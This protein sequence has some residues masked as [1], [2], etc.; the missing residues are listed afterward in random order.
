MVFSQP[1]NIILLHFVSIN[2]CIAAFASIW[3]KKQNL[4][5]DLLNNVWHD[6]RKGKDLKKAGKDDPTRIL[7]KLNEMLAGQ[8][9]PPSPL[10]LRLLKLFWN[11]INLRLQLLLPLLWGEVWKILCGRRLQAHTLKS[12][13]STQTTATTWSTLTTRGHSCLP[14][15]PHWVD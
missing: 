14:V 2:I 12:H 11:V 15:F 8:R 1:K 4:L 13:T 7:K 10:V 5:S 6:H 9:W 3:V